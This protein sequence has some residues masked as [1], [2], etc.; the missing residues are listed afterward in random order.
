MVGGAIALALVLYLCGPRLARGGEP[1]TVLRTYPLPG[2]LGAVLKPEAGDYFEVILPSSAGYLLW[3]HWPVPI[4]VQPVEAPPETAL[5]QRETQWQQAVLGA[6]ADWSVYVPLE[7]TRQR[8]SA[9]I[10]VLRQQ[11][12]LRWAGGP[13]LRQARQGETRYRI[14]ADRDGQGQVCL[15][16]QQTVYVGDRQGAQQLRGTVRHELGHALGLWGH[17]PDP[18]DVLSAHQGADPPLI[19][20]RD[21]NTLGRL[22]RQSTRLGCEIGPSETAHGS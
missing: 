13:L 20:Q 3:S 11:P 6:I 17:S 4:Y 2:R 16:H 15:R 22:Y 10:V 7:T 1:P 21:I 9:Q 19:S 18:Q 12:P 5:H 8:A 14:F